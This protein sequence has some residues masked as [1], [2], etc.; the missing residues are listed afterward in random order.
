MNDIRISLKKRGRRTVVPLLLLLLVPAA[1]RAAQDEVLTL[2]SAIRLALSRNELALQADQLLNAA[3]ARVGQARAYF[4]PTLTGTGT[5]TRRPFEV[6]RSVGSTEIVVQSL[7]GIA[8]VALLNLTIF[9]SRSLPALLRARSD[10]TAERYAT[11]EAKRQLAFEVGNAFL[12]TLGV[13]Q[14]LDA[15]KHRFEYARQGLEAARARYA[16]GL[17]SV[18][19]VTRAELEY[20][21]AEM[22]ITQVQGQVETTYL[23]LGNLLD[24]KIA[25]GRKLQIPEFLLQAAEIE[26]TAVEDLIAQAQDRRLD[27][28]S[29]RWRA[30]ALHALTIEP[31]LKWLPALSFNGQYRYTNEAGL[32]GRSTNW[33]VGLTMTWSVFDGLARNSEYSERKANAIL[34]DLEVQAILRK[35]ELDVRDAFVSLENQRAALKQATVANEVAKRNAAETAELYRQG[36]GTA[37]QVADANV[38]LFEAEVTLVQERYGLAIAYLNLE[39]ALGFDPFGK[40]PLL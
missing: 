8:G 30:K 14:V 34:S 31:L 23:Q 3:E 17:V 11:A 12:T 37:L 5:Y 36:L 6:K 29:L 33:N 38:R 22:G 21:T 26:R 25:A 10:R 13:D 32:T 27:L 15:A 4:L 39:A 16:A 9:D 7:N 28:T 1:L 24:E 18:N 20:A 2:E 19:D 35:V 40:E